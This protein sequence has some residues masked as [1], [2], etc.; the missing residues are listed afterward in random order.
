MGCPVS[1]TLKHN[2]GVR[3]MGDKKY[4]GDIVK[5]LKILPDKPVSVKLSG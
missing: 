5:L 1:H 4:A 2:W 3:L